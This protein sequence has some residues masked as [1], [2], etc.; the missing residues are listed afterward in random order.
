VGIVRLT[1]HQAK[2]L[3]LTKS[4]SGDLNPFAKVYTGDK[5]CIHTTPRFKHTINPVWESATEFLCMDRSSSV[6]TVTVVDDRGFVKDPV[7]GYMA[8]KIE[9]LLIAKK[10]SGRDWWPLS[11]C[12]SG[13][14]RLSVE[15]KPLNMAGSLQGADRYVPP[16][17]VV[18][19][20]LEKAM[21]L[22]C[23]FS[24]F[25]STVCIC[26]HM[27]FKGTSKPLWAAR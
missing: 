18:R 15:W 22:K 16:I 20:H 17:G 14:I 21:D 23:V 1:I 12:K 4:I 6:V 5:K 25:I 3:D 8:I 10:E 7:L 26:A 11:N 13:K 24:S 19:L 2:E 9:D 27:P